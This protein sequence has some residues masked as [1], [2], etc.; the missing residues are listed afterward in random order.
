MFDSI[1]HIDGNTAF[2]AEL[3]QMLQQFGLKI[4]SI[5]DID[6]LERQL[7][8]DHGACVLADSE[9]TVITAAELLLRIKHLANAPPV[10][11]L[12]ER[13]D[14]RAA[15]YLLNRGASAYLLKTYSTTEIVRELLRVYREHKAQTDA[16]SRRQIA[17]EKL[18]SMPATRLR[19]LS[20]WLAGK[21]IAGIADEVHLS[22]R[23]VKYHRTQLTRTYDK[24]SIISVAYELWE[25]GINLSDIQELSRLQ[26]SSYPG[27][28]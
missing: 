17:L 28:L 2:Q 9:P 16:I 27:S 24:S 19:I 26:N 13:N 15:Q 4:E 7:V 22:T 10:V 5:Q 23:T 6:H 20:H 11:I 18:K 8:R 12:S 1:Y 25:C 3:L 21:T 14:L